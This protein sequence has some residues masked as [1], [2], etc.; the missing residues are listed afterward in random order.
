[1]RILQV[2]SERGWRGGE[3]QTLLTAQ[4]LRDRGHD[5]ALLVRAGGV[6]ETRARDSGLRTYT[7]NTIAQFGG[8]LASHGRSYDV[9]HVQTANVLAWAL[10]AKLLHRRPVVFSRRT[11]FPIRGFS[12]F[13]RLK[14]ASTDVRVAISEAA[15][16]AMRGM[17]L[18]VHIIPSAVPAVVSNPARVQAF[19]EREQLHGQRLVGT[20]AALSPEKDPVTLIHAA[21]R[22]C[23]RYPDV[24]FVHWGAEGAA[25]DAARRAIHDLGLD[26]RY[27]LL[28]FESDVEQ[29]FPALKVFV[30]S[31]RHEALGSS[32]LDAMVQRV[33]VVATQVG[34]LKELLADGR[35][36]LSAPGDVSGLADQ[37]EVQ[38]GDP[39]GGLAMAARAFDEVRTRYA[40]QTMVQAYERL[41]QQ[42][43]VPS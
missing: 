3:R 13:S 20:A 37:I 23:A 12:G 36:L 31:S 6:L 11:S 43:L 25:A 8:W 28:G 17:R 15:A 40:V 34:G 22:V 33:P 35:G 38:L 1:M 27:R 21:A 7:V 32:V 30:M 39:E 41:Y 10:L 24:T 19:I 2:N 18:S 29:L 26:M 14:W 5:V 9:L 42:V 4:G 16:D